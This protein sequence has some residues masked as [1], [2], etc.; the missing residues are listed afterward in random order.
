MSNLA[1]YIFGSLFL[2]CAIVAAYRLIRC[3]KDGKDWPDDY[4][5]GWG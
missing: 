5:D 3:I 4:P 2:L 1:A